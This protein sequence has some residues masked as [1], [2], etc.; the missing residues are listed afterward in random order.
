[1]SLNS[2]ESKYENG[3]GDHDYIHGF[4]TLAELDRLEKQHTFS[5]K[6]LW[7]NF[8][9][10]EHTS[11][12][13]KPF[14]DIGCG[15]AAQ[16]PTLL[17]VLPQDINVIGIDID[18]MKINR[19]K[20]KMSN[21]KEYYGRFSFFVMD[22]TNLSSF[23]ENQFSG[24]HICWVL[25]HLTS[26]KVLSLLKEVRRVVAP[27]GII[28]INEIIMEPDESFTI[29]SL[30]RCPL[31]LKEYLYAMIKAQSMNRG[32]ANFGREDNMKEFLKNA[33]FSN[34][35]YEKKPLHNLNDCEWQ[36]EMKECLIDVLSSVTPILNA[37][38]T[39]SY[40]KFEKVKEELRSYN[41]IMQSFGSVRIENIK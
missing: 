2:I 25:E 24:A 23:S 11:L 34:F 10:D 30:N 41:D 16:T 1:M 27:K 38:G 26:D 32:N 29:Q 40:E 18:P 19:A 7:K 17:S 36:N 20:V 6:P 13:T 8:T 4:D 33:G 35:S 21:M 22:A 15:V 31:L 39:F 37:S 14:L 5:K 12:S 9:L 3:L 28:L